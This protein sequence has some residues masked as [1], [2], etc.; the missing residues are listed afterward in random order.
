[1][2][3]PSAFGFRSTANKLGT[4]R[5]LTSQVQR[6]R[7]LRSSPLILFLIQVF[8]LSHGVAA[9]EKSQFQNDASVSRKAEKT[10]AREFSLEVTEFNDKA[11]DVFALLDDQVEGRPV[12]LT[13]RVV[14]KSK[15]NIKRIRARSTCACLVASIG[16]EIELKPDA[17]VKISINLRPGR[18]VSKES[19]QILGQ[20]E[21]GASA[22]LGFF[23]V[24]SQNYPP[25][26]PDRTLIVVEKASS[27][28]ELQLVPAHSSIVIEDL[29]SIQL[30]SKIV[31]VKRVE[32]AGGVYRV[33]IGLR[34]G[35]VFPKKDFSA[36]IRAQFKVGEVSGLAMDEVLTF[37]TSPRFEV[38]PHVVS[39]TRNREDGVRDTLSGSIVVKN[40]SEEKRLYFALIA[41]V[42]GRPQLIDPDVQADG[43][44]FV[45]GNSGLDTFSIAATIY[46]V[47]CPEADEAEPQYYLLIHGSKMPDFSVGWSEFVQENDVFA[48]KIRSVQLNVKTLR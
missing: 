20:L 36:V 17:E 16:D 27:D 13:L 46:S 26:R 21:S 15:E 41:D 6:F 18:G 33:Q 34:D 9:Q 11:S 22:H 2:K 43:S 47:E 30:D 37:V 8:A 31:E 28:F 25:L 12:N 42:N 40:F 48:I 19:V 5:Y 23:S 7:L 3:P 4:A 10:K 24:E 45:V 29:K 35:A 38:T 39:M 44:K 14:N 1:M 32:S